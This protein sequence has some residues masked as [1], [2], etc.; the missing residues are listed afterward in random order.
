MSE[1]TY[2]LG[3]EKDFPIVKEFYVKLDGVFR[4]YGFNL[5]EPEDLGQAYL[6]SF[7][8]TLGR[9][10]Q[11]WVAEM[12]GEVVAY[13]LMRIKHTPLFM[14]GVTVGE[15]SDAW[16]EPQAR[17]LGIGETLCHMGVEWMREQKVHSVEIS[18]LVGNEAS[19]GMLKPF[20]F[21][22]ELNQYRLMWE[23]YIPAD[24]DG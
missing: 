2:R 19:W 14:G 22:P 13:A 5:P 9:F 24:K 10:S 16:I 17:R 8:R 11:F 1:V 18:I 21:K 6:D 4:H 12:D 7:S 20:G 3:T 23:D 15:I